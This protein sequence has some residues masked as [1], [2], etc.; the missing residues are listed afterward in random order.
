MVLDRL[1]C[2]RPM[3]R[4]Q[5]L[6]RCPA[7]DDRRPSLS[8]RELPD[9]VLLVNC[10]ASC[11]AADVLAAVGLTLGDLYPDNP[12][13]RHPTPTGRRWDWRGLLHVLRFE[14]EIVAQCAGDVLQRRALSA[15]DAA[16]LR[17]AKQ[18]IDRVARLADD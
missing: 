4:D 17:Q 11:G 2:V 16:R 3:G 1:E 9:G 14:S 15:D 18:R 12:D 7:H 6:A 13:N 5:W 8:V 10:F